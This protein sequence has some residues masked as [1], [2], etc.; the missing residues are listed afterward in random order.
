[1]RRHCVI[2]FEE[3]LMRAFKLIA[4]LSLFALA[5]CATDDP[6]DAYASG[7]DPNAIRVGTATESDYATPVNDDTGTSGRMASKRR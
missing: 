3:T 1:M 6:D 5:A 4:A 7:N 2:A